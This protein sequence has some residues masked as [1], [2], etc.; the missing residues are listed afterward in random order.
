MS[1]QKWRDKE[2]DREK[3]RSKGERGDAQARMM[4]RGEGGTLPLP[5]VDPKFPAICR[6]LA[7]RVRVREVRASASSS[8]MPSSKDG[9]KIFGK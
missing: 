5:I 6:A 9:S 7:R 4:E 1:F 2:R 3:I 8:R